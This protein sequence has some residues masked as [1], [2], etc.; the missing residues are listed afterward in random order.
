M[1]AGRLESGGANIKIALIGAELE[2]NLG[3]RYMAAVLEEDGHE[4]IVVPFNSESEISLVAAQVTQM[5]PQIA[6]LSMVFTG[7]AREFC[8]LAQ[9]LRENGFTGHLVA[10]GHF[11]SF[12]AEFLLQ[13]FPAFDSIGLCEGEEVMRQLARHLDDLGAVPALWLSTA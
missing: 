6:G 1:A 13:N 4:V 11:A 12:N 7:R 5:A 2:E 3:L 8:R 10:G 9:A